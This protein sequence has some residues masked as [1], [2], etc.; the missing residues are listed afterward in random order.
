MKVKPLKKYKTPFYPDKSAVL[1]NPNI[2]KAMP[3]RWKD[4]ASVGFVLSSTILLLQTG[5]GN[6]ITGSGMDT[7]MGSE[8]IS[9]HGEIKPLPDTDPI[10]VAPIFEHGM[11]RGSFGCV[12]VAP[13]TFLSEAEA[14]EVIN[15]EA[16]REGIIF[17]NEMIQLE[18]IEIPVTDLF[19]RSENDGNTELKTIKETLDLDGYDSE[20]KIAVEFVSKDDVVAWRDKNPEFLSSVETYDALGAAKKLQEGLKDKTD[21]IIT[22]VFYDPMGFD[23]QIY[24]DY[25]KEL[26]KI[27]DNTE[28][29]DEQ[30]NLQWKELSIKYEEAVKE[31]K[32]AMLREQV[33]DFLSWLKA[34]GII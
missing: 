16:G 18:N 17:T 28:L 1:R 2:L 23:K 27:S 10:L 32:T 7:N 15:E 29:S 26:R 11:G 31:S 5:C 34:Q 4:R 22:G 21:G 12:S 6:K 14:L 13:P 9:T 24:D 20:R 33:K 19:P 25:S 30:K 3:Q 8:N